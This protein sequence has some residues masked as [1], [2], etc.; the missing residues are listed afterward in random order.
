MKKVLIAFIALIGFNVSGMAQAITTPVKKAENKMKAVPKPTAAPAK[1]VEMPKSLSKIPPAEKPK[2]VATQTPV[3]K[4]A[5]ARSTPVVLKKDGTPDKR[6]N[7]IPAGPVK[8]DGTPDL[9]YKKNKKGKS[10]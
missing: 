5:A 8:N 2:T 4:P 10:E 7:K 6:Y 9:R 1:L 3:A